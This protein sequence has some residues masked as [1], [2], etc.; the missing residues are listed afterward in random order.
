MSCCWAGN[1]SAFFI[2][3]DGFGIVG[4]CHFE[5]DCAERLSLF[6]DDLGERDSKL[7]QTR[8]QVGN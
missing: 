6:F 7:G 5:I 8:L 3:G 2:H 1:L 4:T